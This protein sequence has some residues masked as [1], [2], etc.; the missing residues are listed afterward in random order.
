MGGQDTMGGPLGESAW[1]VDV[2]ESDGCLAP[3]SENLGEK[4]MP[5][6]LFCLLLNFHD[7]H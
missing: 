4:N 2:A 5:E 3:V 7:G 1:R 6:R